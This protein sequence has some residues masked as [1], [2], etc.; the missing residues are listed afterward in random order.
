M[1]EI[2]ASHITQDTMIANDK[3]PTIKLVYTKD[4]LQPQVGVRDRT[5]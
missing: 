5:D 1:D 4:G 3:S 2:A